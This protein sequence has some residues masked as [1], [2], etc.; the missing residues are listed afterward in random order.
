MPDRISALLTLHIFTLIFLFFFSILSTL[1]I[2]FI[3]RNIAL[4]KQR[5]NHVNVLYYY[6]NRESGETRSAPTELGSI[7][8]ENLCLY[9]YSSLPVC[10]GSSSYS[11]P[12]LLFAY[13]R[14]RER[15]RGS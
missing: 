12:F 6:V 14:L 11:S 7:L 9:T 2:S 15:A 1:T 10:Y 3:N 5:L 4:N 13:F 8:T